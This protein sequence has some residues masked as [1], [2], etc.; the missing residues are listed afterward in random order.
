MA[1]R[2]T[3]P[4]STSSLPTGKRKYP[5]DGI[6][7]APKKRRA[8]EPQTKVQNQTANSTTTTSPYNQIY[9]PLLAKLRGK[10]EVKTMSVMPSTNISKH[11]DHALE[12][13]GRFDAWDQTVLPGVV[14]LCAK[15]AVSNKLLTIAEVIKRRIHESE[16]K[17]FQYNVLSETISEETA[18]PVAEQSVVEETFMPVDLEGEEGAGDDEYFETMQPTIHERAVQPPKVRHQ[19]HLTILLSRVPVDELKSEKNIF[20][21]T[22]EPRIEYLRKKNMGLVA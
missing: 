1:A 14:L 21:Q 9:S 19:A 22:N 17:W 4:P 3:I 5:S 12:H 16:Q 15:S 20:I 11:V 6:D 10:Y 2:G 8:T 7:L 13:V 18:Q